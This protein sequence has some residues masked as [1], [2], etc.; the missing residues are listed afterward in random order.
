MAVAP[1]VGV[2]WQPLDLIDESKMDDM[3]N[4]IQFV[5]DNTPRAR[6]QIP[7]AGGRTQ[8][9]KIAGGRVTIPRNGK[10][11]QHV[12]PV[13]FAGF[14]TA[15]CQPIVTLGCQSKNQQDIFHTFYG[16]DRTQVDHR[17]MNI[18][19]EVGGEEGG[20]KKG[21]KKQGKI[22]NTFQVH[23]IALGY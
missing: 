21:K 22:R 7:G 4:A 5:H 13:D 16:L 3:S 2:Q 20:G 17:G 10:K 11:D 19:I 14:F 23:W 9:L 15:G 1:F 18:S 12:E 8:G 6:M